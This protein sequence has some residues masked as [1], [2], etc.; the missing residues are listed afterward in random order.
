M[1]DRTNDWRSYNRIWMTPRDGNRIHSKRIRMSRQR[2]MVR[3]GKFWLWYLGICEGEIGK[4]QYAICDKHN[5]EKKEHQTNDRNKQRAFLK[6]D[7]AVPFSFFAFL[8]GGPSTGGLGVK[9]SK[10]SISLLLLFSSTRTEV[11]MAGVMILGQQEEQ[12]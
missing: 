5:V 3:C 8:C 1:A 10:L 9:G 6:F 11:S 2:D 4:N 7:D 12:Q